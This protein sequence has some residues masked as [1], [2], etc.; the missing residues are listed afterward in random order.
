MKWLLKYRRWEDLLFLSQR[1]MYVEKWKR[2]LGTMTQNYQLPTMTKLVVIIVY[3]LWSLFINF[4]AYNCYETDVLGNNIISNS[5]NFMG[6]EGY[7]A[8]TKIIWRKNL[9]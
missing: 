8:A 6:I 2:K 4:F 5:E 3:F 7:T 9:G 1:L